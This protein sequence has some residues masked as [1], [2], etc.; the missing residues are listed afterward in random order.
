MAKS[1]KIGVIGQWAF[2]IGVIVAVIVGLL[3]LAANST[4]AI[5]LMIIGI[6]VGLLN[7]SDK[8]AMPFLLSGAVLIIASY[9]GKGAITSVSIVDLPGILTALM[10]IFVPATIIVAVKNVFSIARN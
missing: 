9:M 5:I 4:V 2:L 6:V 7:V 1:S 3:G 10:A 8:E